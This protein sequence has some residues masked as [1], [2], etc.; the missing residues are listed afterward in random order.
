MRSVQILVAFLAASPLVT[1]RG[2]AAQASTWRVPAGQLAAALADVA[3]QS[4]GE[5]LF[6]PDDV[7]GRLTT[8][9]SGRFTIEQALTR[10]LDGSGL[11]WRRTQDGTLIVYRLTHSPVAQQAVPEIVVTGRRTQDADIRRTRD[12]IQPYRVSNFAE[13]DASHTDGIDSFLRTRLPSDA[14]TIAPLQDPGG[15][16]GSIRSEINLHGLGADQTLVLVDGLRMPSVPGL[17]GPLLQPD[18]AAIPVIAIDRVETLTGTAGGIYGPGA[19]GGVVN[20]VLSRSYHG[21]GLTLDS[22]ATQDGGGGR[23][24]IEARAGFSPDGG[25]TQVSLIAG[26]QRVTGIDAGQRSLTETGQALASSNAPIDYLYEARTAAAI[27]VENQYGALTLKPSYGGATLKSY[28]TWLPLDTS[29][30][31]ASIGTQLLAHDGQI[32]TALS[33]DASGRDKSLLS[34]GTSA[35]LIGSVRHRLAPGVD[36]FVDVIDLEDHGRARLPPTTQQ[37]EVTTAVPTN[38][39]EE[40][41]AVTFPLP[42]FGVDASTRVHSVRATAGLVAKVGRGWTLDASVG[43]GN[44]TQTID[45][46]GEVLSTAG[47]L[48]MANGTPGPDGGPVLDPFGDYSDFLQAAAAYR[49][50]VRLH[51]RERDLFRDANL[52]FAGPLARLPGGDLTVTTL[53]EHRRERVP[54]TALTALNDVRYPDLQDQPGTLLL[55]ESAYGEVRVPLLPFERR[56]GPVRGL[57]LQFAVRHDRTRLDAPGFTD[58]LGEPGPTG[59]ARWPTTSVTAGLRTFPLRS[60]MLRASVATGNLPPNASQVGG[61]RI[62]D[63]SIFDPRRGNT[64][65][66]TEVLFGGSLRLQPEHAQAVSAGFVINP[67]ARRWPRLSLDWLRI[68]KSNEISNA[69]GM[70]PNYFVANE[71]IYADRVVRAPL[72]D[73]DR[74]QG[75]TAG[76]LV[77]VDATDLNSGRSRLE[78]VDIDLDWTVRSVAGGTLTLV[79]AATWEP[80]YRRQA[81][82]DQPWVRIDGYADGPLHWR[83]SGGPRWSRGPLT[84]GISGQ[85]YSPYRSTTSGLVPSDEVLSLQGSATIPA[86]FYL[87]LDAAYQLRLPHPVFLRAGVTNVLDHAPPPY[88]Q[89]I[90]SPGYSYFGDPRLRRFSL[91]ISSRF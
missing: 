21:A 37:F 12:D 85:Y 75:Y 43:I 79:G 20:V 51:V 72:T 7:A 15:Q 90:N 48:T 27:F 70:D 71:D 88:V 47:L 46:H 81:A 3:R 4:G 80:V 28:Y 77:S 74:E 65:I 42:G 41:V 10:L 59:R 8:G 39:F 25:D 83:A 89:A 14:E 78:T 67:N 44:A 82:P 50:P 29:R 58:V 23:W 86:Q 6:T 2:A 16:N 60:L 69:H 24:R 49:V 63:Y 22:A 61:F 11:S 35:A 18:I 31:A 30:A 52:R 73:A 68:A 34:A 84:L 91:S 66:V 40:D 13:I 32:P 9:L 56:T 26:W 33:P 5:L 57:E 62:P 87:D 38:P 36:A 54:E 17:G 53:F 76:A 55:A 19:I 1:S 64:L 45:R